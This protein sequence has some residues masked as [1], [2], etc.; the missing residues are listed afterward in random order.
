MDALRSITNR[1]RV[2]ARARRWI[3]ALGALLSI[4]AIALPAQAQ[5]VDIS[6]TPLYGGRSPHPNVAVSMSVEFPSVGA[7]YNGIAYVAT[8]TYLGYFDSTQCYRYNGNSTNG[9]FRP[10]GASNAAHQCSNAFSGNFMNWATMSSIDEFRYAMTGGNRID[11]SGPSGGTIIQ[12]AFLPDGS[13]AGVPSFYGPYSP[14]FPRLVIPDALAQ[15]V[16]PNSVTNGS[17]IYVTNCKTQVF[18]GFNNNGD[19]NSPDDDG[20]RSSFNVSINVCDNAEGPVR[21]DLCLGYGTNGGRP[22]KPVGEAQRNAAK[23]RFSVFGYLMDRNTAGYTVPG[24]CDDGSTWNRCRYGGVLRAPMK[25]IGPTAYDANLTGSPNTTKEIQTNGD[26]IDDPENSAASAGGSYS[27]FLN[28]INK[29]GR[30]GTYKRYDTM[31]EMYYEAVRYFQGLQPTPNAYSGS[32]NNAVKDNFPLTTTW[33]DPI[34]SRCSANYIINLSDANTWDDSY[35]PGYN[36]SPGPGYGRAGSRPAEG[37]LDSYLWTQ[38]VGALE[39]TTSSIT[40][41]DVRPGLSNLANQ[42]TGAGPATYLPTG[43][44][45]WANTN[46]V[47]SDLVGKQTIKTISFDVAEPSIDIHDRQ[48]YLMGKYGGFNNTIDRAVDGTQQNPFWA[49]NPSNPNGPAIRTNSEWED[50]P[51]SAYPSN[52]LLA[53]D[54]QKLINGLR[55]AFARINSQTGTLSGASLTSANL[56]YGAAGAY[57]A[58]FDPA[59]WSG[60][61]LFNSL[62]VDPI[63]G[64]L[65]V[66]SAPIWDSGALLNARCGTVAAA[67]TVCTDTSTN[68]ARRNIVT[69]TQVAGTRTAVNFTYANIAADPAYVTPLNTNPT[70]GLIDGYAQQRVN[71]LRGYRADE[72]TLGFRSRDSAM[73]DI[74]NSGPIYVGAPSTS[75]PESDY[76]AFYAANNART[77]AVYVGANDGMLHAIRASSGVELFSYVPGFSSKYLSDLTSPSYGHD[78]FVDTVPKVQEV[79]LNGTWKTLLLGANGA[80]S[81][82]I[83]ALDVTDPTTFGPSKVLFEFSDAD[84]ADFGNVLAAP[85]IAKLR[86]GTASGV[87]VYRY[88]A[89]V[90][91]YNNKRTDVN[92]HTSGDTSVSSDTQNKGVLFLIALDHALN[93]PWV[94]NTDYYKYTFPASN[95]A[96]VNALGPVSLLPSA[97]GDRSTAALYFGDLQGN[98]WRFNTTGTSPSAW[99]PARGTPSVPAPIF[100]ATDASNNRQPI[101]ARPELASGPFGST[102]VFF[103]TGRYLGQADLGLPGSTQSEYGIL[104]TGSS[105]LITRSGDLVQRTAALS[106][107]NVTITGS[108]FS[109]SGPS[110]KKGWYLDFPSSGTIGERSVTKP[111]I[112]T[113]L[114]TFTTLTLSPDIC[115]G[116]S[117][118]IYQ[119]N[120]LTGL[121]YGN[122]TYGGYTSTVGIPGPPRIVDLTITNT[123]T[124]P[125]GEQIKKQTQ[126]TLVSGTLGKIDTP[127]PVILSKTPPVGRINW[128]E[129]TNWND[130][131]GN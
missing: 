58:T 55:A 117:G 16:L 126:A 41:N 71:Y 3:G 65:V 111:A 110:A 20:G 67:S 123:V 19:C 6:D 116:G 52:Y 15:T 106:G 103:G 29:F 120:A 101:T 75:I 91:G 2:P 40:S 57:I 78:T 82:G 61:V 124:R 28:Y 48:L 77:P 81:Q 70:S 33:V 94:L 114:L 72:T 54:P 17:T 50:S 51:G 49:T 89:V 64:L 113:G 39:S 68:P 99:A 84:D 76:Q 87:P 93:A 109:Y 32:Y 42:N 24:G 47:R 88:F 128:R 85:E 127:G 125:T 74:I 112:R 121:P 23:M 108:V 34:L 92:G 122:A 12:R 30:T 22:Y 59:R 98:M 104:D 79:K 100:T 10:S 56:T 5:L 90:T 43:I 63:T 13:V 73:G 60:S 95:S 119:V 9:R 129:I 44:A 11:E 66:S 21:T 115:G 83:F 62:S 37:G 69:V 4:A 86:V 46:D 97:S 26:M 53:S 107:G 1:P 27:G 45:Y 38:K 35:V 36:G 8:N 80:G 18:F 118:Y 96:L 131:T 7:A 105:A 102:L 25:Y 31:G 14:N 130:L